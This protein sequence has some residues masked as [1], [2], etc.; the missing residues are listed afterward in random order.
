MRRA[1]YE[2]ASGLMT[3]SKGKD[4]VKSWGQQIAKR[5]CHCKACVAVVC[6]LAVIMHAM[7][8]DGAFYVG[9]PA[10]TEI[11]TARRAQVTDCKLL[12]AHP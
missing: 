1:L 2:A 5:S 4:R 8:S 7:W 11:D 3:R 9:D 12:G 10:A 6:K